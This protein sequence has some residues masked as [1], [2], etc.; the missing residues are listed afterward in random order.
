MVLDLLREGASLIG[1]DDEPEDAEPTPWQIIDDGM[2]AA[3]SALRQRLNGTELEALAPLMLEQALRVAKLKDERACLVLRN[4]V[5]FRRAENWPLPL[6]VSAIGSTCLR[7]GM[8][9]LLPPDRSGCPVL[10]YKAASLDPTAHPIAAYQRLG[11]Y[12]VEVITRAPAVQHGGITLLLD[13]QNVSLGLATAFGVADVR[14]GIGMWR[15]TFPAKLTRLCIVNAPGPILSLM[16]VG[17]YMLTAK[18]RRRVHVF[19]SVD[20][21]VAEVGAAALPIELGGDLPPTYWDDWCTQREALEGARVMPHAADV[22]LQATRPPDSASPPASPPPA[23]PPTSPPVSPLSVP[24]FPPPP[25]AS[26]R[27]EMLAPLLILCTAILTALAAALGEMAT[28]EPALRGLV[29]AGVMSL[30]VGIHAMSDHPIG[31]A[32]CGAS[33][34]MLARATWHAVPLGVSCAL[35]IGAATALPGIPGGLRPGAALL[36]VASALTLVPATAAGLQ[37]SVFVRFVEVLAAAFHRSFVCALGTI[38]HPGA[39][40][41]AIT[42]VGATLGLA[43][44]YAM[45]PPAAYHAAVP[46][47]PPPPHEPPAADAVAGAIAASSGVTDGMSAAV[48]ALIGALLEMPRAHAALATAHTPPMPPLVPSLTP[49]LAR[50]GRGGRAVA[51]CMAYG[52]ILL[53]E[54]MVATRPPPTL[55]VGLTRAV[56]VA[57]VCGFVVAIAPSAP[58]MLRASKVLIGAAGLSDVALCGLRIGSSHYQ[59][60]APHIHGEGGTTW[61]WHKEEHPRLLWLR[62]AGALATAATF[63]LVRPSSSSPATTEMSTR[64]RRPD[65]ARTAGH[66]HTH[67]DDPLHRRTRATAAAATALFLCAHFVL[68]LTQPRLEDAVSVSFHFVLLIGSFALWAVL[69]A[70]EMALWLARLFLASEMAACGVRLLLLL[71]LAHQGEAREE[72]EQLGLEVVE[73][74]SMPAASSGLLAAMLAALAGLLMACL[75]RVPVTLEADSNFLSFDDETAGATIKSAAPRA[76][77]GPTVMSLP[78]LRHDAII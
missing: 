11:S 17:L 9:Q 35:M 13:L 78:P 10:Y 64:W 8:H 37:S 5:K 31:L 56:H 47:P 25:S 62:A 38:V 76:E 48:L 44:C 32:F 6:T 50:M 28:G 69:K 41:M 45:L 14:R 22:T 23:S 65:H 53:W 68:A 74:D 67:N 18:M 7:S 16:R 63:A 20:A 72:G 61:A 15:N 51:A 1:D 75:A 77:K 21:L 46:L 59:P 34:A 29:H 43:S 73:S 4:L 55:I 39:E 30:F 2:P 27:L 70:S 3:M 54:A 40:P 12:L 36:T 66:C 24:S 49:P 58:H 60:V 71:L 33:C 52:A 26:R 19:D 42:F 57:A